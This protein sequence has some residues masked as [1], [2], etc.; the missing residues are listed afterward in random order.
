VVDE[1]TQYIREWLKTRHVGQAFQ[2]AV[3]WPDLRSFTKEDLS[4]VSQ[5]RRRLPHWE[6]EGS[7][8]FVTF[9]VQKGLGGVLC[10][11]L[12]MG[13]LELGRLESLPHT[14]L[15]SM[16]EEALW[17]G[18]GGRY[19]LDAYVVMPDH[20]HLLVRPL[21]DW[22][23]GRVLQGI[24]GFTARESNR[25]LGRRGS[26]W[27]DEN[28]DHLI[29]NESDWIDKFGYIHNNPVTAGL[30][31]R[32]QDYPYSSLVSMHSKGRLESLPH[33]EG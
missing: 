14:P 27:Q 17:F 6:L 22:R 10:G 30:V 3:H 26:F 9:R 15:A 13:R 1:R 32:P 4:L 21:A 7:T 11:R 29:R 31:E 23:L 18:Y 2:P 16:V 25:V 33:I 12:E 28:F 24:K 20:V 19:V 5:Y 8:Y